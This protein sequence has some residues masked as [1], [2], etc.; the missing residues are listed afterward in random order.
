MK[1]KAKCYIKTL[2]YGPP[3]FPIKVFLKREA[4]YLAEHGLLIMYGVW[5]YEINMTQHA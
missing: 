4:E 5:W 3:P 1:A 2:Q